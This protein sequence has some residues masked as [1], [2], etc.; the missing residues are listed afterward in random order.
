[1]KRRR[2]EHN[3]LHK[4]SHILRHRQTYIKIKPNGQQQK[5]WQKITAY[6]YRSYTRVKAIRAYR[7]A[8]CRAGIW[9]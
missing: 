7:M 5:S 6:D 3:L 2:H 4:C 9:T 8:W 1:M